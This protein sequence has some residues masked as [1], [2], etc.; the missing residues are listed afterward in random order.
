[1][2]DSN[3]EQHYKKY[4][5]VNYGSDVPDNHVQ[6]MLNTSAKEG[7]LKMLDYLVKEK[8]A[9]VN[10][11]NGKD[12]ALHLAA[13]GGNVLAGRKLLEHGAKIDHQGKEGNT[14]LHEASIQGKSEFT[15]LLLAAGADVTV[16]NKKG[17]TALDVAQDNVYQLDTELLLKEAE[18]GKR[19]TWEELG[20]KPPL[21]KKTMTEHAAKKSGS[22]LPDL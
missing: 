4:I 8:N 2:A 1:M 16:K 18:Q 6:R 11:E 13:E 3:L 21:R 22:S 20:I 15:S 17:E 19:P 10:V 12:S 9:S 7:D 5:E 14:P